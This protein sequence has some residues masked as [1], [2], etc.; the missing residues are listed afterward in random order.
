[1]IKSYFSKTRPRNEYG[2]L[3]RKVKAGGLLPAG[4]RIGG[5][6]MPGL[7]MVVWCSYHVLHG[8]GILSSNTSAV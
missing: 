3:L 5:A 1:M 8:E 4:G 2:I 7:G 6:W